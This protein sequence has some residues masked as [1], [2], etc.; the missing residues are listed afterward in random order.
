MAVINPDHLLEQARRLL[1][2]KNSRGL[3][4]QAERCRAISAAYY[5]VFHYTLTAL[6]DELVGRRNRTSSRYALVYRRLDHA[7]L[8]A[9]CKE[10]R[11]VQMPA[12]YATYV[13]ANGWG[14][15]IKQFASLVIELKEKRNAADYDPSFWVKIADAMQ[16]IE[17]ARSAIAG[18]ER[19]SV[20][21][22]K[23]FLTLL[24]FPPR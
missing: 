24:L 20:S 13:P 23:A 3:V 12:K 6:A 17:S 14:D 22:K 1:E 10:V 18:F 21:R 4:R 5:A 19:A 15:N 11:K 9:L 16:A 8:E 7:G 2:T